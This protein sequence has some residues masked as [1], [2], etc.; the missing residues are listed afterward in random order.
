MLQ[1]RSSSGLTK[2]N[3]SSKVE[4]ITMLENINNSA[5]KAGGDGN[6]GAL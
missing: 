4:R 3:T 6:G 2:L 5:D 1:G